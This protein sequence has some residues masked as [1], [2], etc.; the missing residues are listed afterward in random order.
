MKEFGQDYAAQVVRNA[1][2]LA[3]ALAEHGFPVACSALGFTKSHQVYLDYGSFGGGKRIARS[4][5]KANIIADCGV[6]LG[7]C[8]ATRKGMKQKEMLQIADLIKRVIKD[9][10][11]SSR[12]KAEVAKLVG[13]FQEI[14][15]CFE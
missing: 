3:R 10:E 1:Q 4:L 2:T 14:R 11:P 9:R 12:I 15:Y 6:R 5:E 8:E 13:E 7:V